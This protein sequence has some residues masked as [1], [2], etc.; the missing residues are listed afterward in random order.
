M[1]P[2]QQW[3]WSFTLFLVLNMT[4]QSG[5]VAL[6]HPG[7]GAT[8]YSTPTWHC[9]NDWPILSCWI[10]QHSWPVPRSSH[11]IC[12]ATPRV[13]VRISKPHKNCVGHFLGMTNGPGDEYHTPPVLAEVDTRNFSSTTS[14]SGDV[15]TPA[16]LPMNSLMRRAM[17]IRAQRNSNMSMSSIAS[18]RTK[19]PLPQ[20]KEAAATPPS[21]RTEATSDEGATASPTAGPKTRKS[22]SSKAESAVEETPSVPRGRPL[23]EARPL[24]EQRGLEGLGVM[25]Q[26]EQAGG[27]NLQNEPSPDGSMGRH[28]RSS[29]SSALEEL[30]N[31]I[32]QW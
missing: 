27:S 14:G 13:R 19:I 10:S 2:M 5:P 17:Q 9:S 3:L 29:S 21:L 15:R 32:P 20:S 16:P 22:G 24:A 18:A 12:A 30:Q 25:R 26:R 4:M 1:P 31:D 23:R 8:S 6:Q 7:A 11:G 28:G